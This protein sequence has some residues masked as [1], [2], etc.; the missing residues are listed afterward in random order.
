MNGIN[1]MGMKPPPAKTIQEEKSYWSSRRGEF[2]ASEWNPNNGKL[3]D[4]KWCRTHQHTHQPF[5]IQLVGKK[6]IFH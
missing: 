5:L 1:R 6:V 3:V 2:I 4:P